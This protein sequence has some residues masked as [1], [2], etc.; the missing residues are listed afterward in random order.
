MPN[1]QCDGW[2][3]QLGYGRKPMTNLFIEFAN[4]Q[5]VGSGD[6]MVGPF[7][8]NGHVQGDQVVIRKQY[9]GQHAIDYHGT[10][11]GEGVYFGDWRISGYV[12]GK[13][14]IHVRSVAEGSESVIS[15]IGRP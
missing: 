1:F 10:Y 5:L 11:N 15:E 8:L 2:W 7:V 13:W 9:L 3:E 14:S 6:D 4:G 12:G